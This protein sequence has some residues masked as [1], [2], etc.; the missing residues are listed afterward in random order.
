MSNELTEKKDNL[1]A[2][3]AESML[4]DAERASGFDNVGADD[5]AIPFI[6]ILQALSPQCRGETAIE[7]A[8]EGD[9]FNT[10]TSIIHKGE[11]KLI[12]CAY[13]KAYIEW[14]PRDSGGGFVKEHSDSKILEQC[15]QNDR[16][17]DIMP[18][19]N[20]IVTTAYHFCIQVKGDGTFE[21]V[22][23]SFS[24]TQLKKSRKWNS[25][26][27]ALMVN[28]SGKKVRPPMFSHIYKARSVPEKN[29][30]GQWAGWQI[31]S[32]ELITDSGLYNVAKRFSEDV[33]KGIVKVAPPSPDTAQATTKPE[34]GD[35][36]VL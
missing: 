1:P 33:I 18:N 35:E 17:Q 8:G 11:I 36:N 9:F 2:N 4:A 20:N 22:V 15:K 25:T 32:P 21:R 12:P 30:Q 29:E 10:V 16:R 19:G 31:G 23:L 13:K 26:M 28:I 3:M 7:G 34:A 27:M 24:S 5:V 6:T 14:I